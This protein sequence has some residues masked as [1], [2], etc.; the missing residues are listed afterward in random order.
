MALGIWLGVFGYL[1][2]SVL[3]GAPASAVMYSSPT[4]WRS[5]FFPVEVCPS[6]ALSPRDGRLR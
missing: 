5:P 6:I 1:R 3:R 4:A 2:T